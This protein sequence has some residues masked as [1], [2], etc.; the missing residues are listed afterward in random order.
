LARQASLACRYIEVV[1]IDGCRSL[2]LTVVNS[3]PPR[4][5]ALR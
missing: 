2:S 3:A 4:V 1:D 5:T